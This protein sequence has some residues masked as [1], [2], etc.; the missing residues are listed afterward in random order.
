M[1]TV[2]Y[3]PLIDS[4]PAAMP[5]ISA[6]T[7]ERRRGRPFKARLGANE[8]GFGPSPKA[9][10]AMTANAQSDIWKYGDENS[11]ELRQ[12]LAAHT[13]AGIENIA[14]GEGIDG[15]T[16]HLMRLFV[17]PG[18]KVI[19]SLGGYPTFNYHARG[20]GGEILT[21]PYKD[22]LEDVDALAALAR[23]TNPAI[24]YVVNPDNPMASWHSGVRI[25][26]FLEQL[27]ESTLLCLDEAYGE[28]APA[29]TLPDIAADDP[30]VIRLRTF[31]KAY[32]LAGARVGYA[33]G[34]PNLIQ[35]FDKTRN[36]FGVNHTG[37]AGALAALG[38]TNWL[39]QTLDKVNRAKRRIGQIAAD[40]NVRALP[41]AT[42]FVAIDLGRNGAFSKAVVK[43]CE[44]RDVFIRRPFAAPG[45]RCI[46]VSVGPDAELDVFAQVLSEALKHARG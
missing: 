30:R 42:S 15:L 22:D 7:I 3:T 24:V 27:P 26:E 25:K 17:E 38:D 9:I 41:S 13:N 28:F 5:F 23:K 4:L 45:N 8:N 14:V 40:N 31:S 44:D 36:H 21:V 32:G 6:D 18:V 29:G 1:S 46:R 34:A 35:S 19:T 20:L 37:Q 39:A 2:R 12:A 10:A 11:W 16:G 43:A 33:I